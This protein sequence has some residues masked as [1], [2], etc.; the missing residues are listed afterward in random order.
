MKTFIK[1]CTPYIKEQIESTG[2]T[3]ANPYIY[4][5]TGGNIFIYYKLALLFKLNP[6]YDPNK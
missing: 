6:L 1:T 2:M 3:R 4:S 5:G